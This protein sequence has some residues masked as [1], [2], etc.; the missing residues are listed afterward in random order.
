MIFIE[1]LVDKRIIWIHPINISLKSKALSTCKR[2]GHSRVSKTFLI[3][4]FITTFPT[5]VLLSRTLTHSKVAMMQSEIF[6]PLTKSILLR[7][8]NLWSNRR[9]HV[10]NDFGDY[11]KLKVGHS[12][13]PKKLHSIHLLYFGNQDFGNMPK[14]LHSIRLLYFGNRIT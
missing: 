2:K 9:K 3:S 5:K 7:R 8:N 4:N 12:N 1:S 14:K 13:R 10:C 6:I 11:F